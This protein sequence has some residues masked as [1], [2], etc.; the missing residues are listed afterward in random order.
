MVFK[1]MGLF[2]FDSTVAVAVVTSNG[3]WVLLL[4]CEVEM[5]PVAD[6]WDVTG[7]EGEELNELLS[8]KALLRQSPLRPFFQPSIGGAEVT[9][10]LQYI[11]MLISAVWIPNTIPSS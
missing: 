11:A 8:N 7:K 6:S 10:A 3:I 2:C 9:N 4:M 5:G 1:N